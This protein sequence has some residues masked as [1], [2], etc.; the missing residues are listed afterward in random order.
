LVLGIVVQRHF[1]W[2]RRRMSG[3]SNW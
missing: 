1:P 2:C 3:T